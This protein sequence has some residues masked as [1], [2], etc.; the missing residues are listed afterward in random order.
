MLEHHA[1]TEPDARRKSA[2]PVSVNPRTPGWA[3]FL[4]TTGLSPAVPWGESVA[5]RLLR[6][7]CCVHARAPGFPAGRGGSPDPVRVIRRCFGSPR[8]GNPYR[9]SHRLPRPARVSDG[10]VD[11]NIWPRP[12]QTER[13]RQTREHPDLAP[14]CVKTPWAGGSYAWPWRVR[15]VTCPKSRCGDVSRSRWIEVTRPGVLPGP[16]PCSRPGH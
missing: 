7:G 1:G 4:G 13:L 14:F 5:M 3:R 15:E 11:D 6:S 12:D 2:A 8:R 16:P 9:P 10:H